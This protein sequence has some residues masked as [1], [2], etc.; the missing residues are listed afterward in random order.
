MCLYT[1]YIVSYIHVVIY[2]LYMCRVTDIEHYMFV[3][4]VLICV[5]A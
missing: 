3:K 2:I 1:I 4:L 5:K